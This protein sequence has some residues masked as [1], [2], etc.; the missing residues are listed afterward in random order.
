MVEYKIL[1]KE[2]NE[3]NNSYIIAKNKADELLLFFNKK[4]TLEKIEKAH[5]L[6]AKSKD[7]QD[8]I[9]EKTKLLGFVDEKNGLFYKYRTSGLRP[10]YYFKISDKEGI[11]MEVERG[12]TLA[13]NMD[14]LDVWKCHICEE[15]NYLFLIVP[16]IRQTEKGNDNIIYKK[17]IDRLESFFYKQNYVNINAIFIFGY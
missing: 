10:D 12:K 13:N 9:L 3:N 5:Q 11:I 1:K 16:K 17:V 7:I 6:N 4:E 2:N 8:I 15:A 14:M